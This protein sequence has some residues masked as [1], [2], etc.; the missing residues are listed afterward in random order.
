MRIQR[1]QQKRCNWIFEK[2]ENGA[3]CRSQ[4]VERLELE[5]QSLRESL[6]LLQESHRQTGRTTGML[7]EA[8]RAAYQQGR[9]V[10]VVAADRAH[11]SHIKGM[12]EPLIR[13]ATASLS[14]NA[15][16][17]TFSFKGSI[18]ILDWNS[19]GFDPE[20]LRVR[21]VPTA[22]TFI[23]HWAIDSRRIIRFR[24][25]GWNP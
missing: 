24:P 9:N 13:E 25:V 16:R 6:R 21:G 5:N 11:A 18:T 10:F 22:D 23:D 4:D 1:Y 15:C 12:L 3:W 19:P 17:S 7:K 2:D 14:W 20:S 8:V